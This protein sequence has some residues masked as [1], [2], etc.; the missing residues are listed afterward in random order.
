[1][2]LTAINKVK[3]LKKEKL[4]RSKNRKNKKRDLSIYADKPIEFC[5]EILKIKI[6][7]DEIKEVFLSVRDKPT[8]NVKA[9]HG[10]G[11]SFGL[12]AIIIWWV[13][14][15]GGVAFTTAPS[16]AQVK[17]ILWK[18]IANLYDANKAKLGGRRTTLTIT[19][20]TKN[21]KTVRGI[22]FSAR[23]Y[24]SNSFQ[25]KHDE[26]LLLVIDEA[27]GITPTIDEAFDSCLSGSSNRGVRIGNPLNPNSSF[28]KNCSFGCIKIDVWNHPNVSWAYE[29]VI[30]ESGNKIHRL[31]PQIAKRILKENWQLEQDPIKPQ[32]EWDKDL[33]RD[34]IPGA[35]SVSW[36]ERQRL[37][38]GEDSAYWMSRIEA[39]FPGDDVSGIIP[40]SWLKE[41]RKR[42]DDNPGYWDNLA[43]QYKWRIGVDVS[44]GKDMHAI[45]LWRGNVLYSVTYIQPNDDREDTINLAQYSVSPL[46]DSL[47]DLY[48]CAV[49]STG[50]GAGTL[51]WLKK[52]G[53][54]VKPCRYGGGAE[55]KERYVDRKIELHWELR[56]DLRDGI[57]AIAPLGDD[58]DKVFEEL[59][60]IRYKLDTKDRLY[61][62]KKEATIKRIK[63]SPD[64]GDSV[65]T[66]RENKAL[67]IESYSDN[68]VKKKKSQ[69]A[70]IEQLLENSSAWLN[71][72]DREEA[73]KYFK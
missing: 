33:P 30:N 54:F 49:D 51:A 37:K 15:V 52:N 22:G 45:A 53:Y 31:K 62:E 2:S 69:D 68:T 19:T 50:V 8:T 63:R 21:G 7:T 4:R 24:D 41:A 35:V 58:E 71:D 64:G 20:K 67:M 36:I 44:D 48:T 14:A 23:N 66:A 12:A 56:E 61:C 27:D 17:D 65:I 1:M 42:Y 3:A 39:E 11:K 73:N 13:F 9:G 29:V 55:K 18:E 72:I 40:Q 70:T 34:V 26:L 28:A 60:A 59:A 5:R 25:G 43:S 57:V 16:Y 6:L 38:Y 32:S 47:G 46:I 10:V